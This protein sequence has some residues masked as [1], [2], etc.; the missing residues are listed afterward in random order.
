M[1]K[2]EGADKLNHAVVNIPADKLPRLVKLESGDNLQHIVFLDDIIRDNL[3]CI[4]TGFTIHACYSF[5]ITR[6]SELFLDEEIIQEDMLQEMEKKLIKRDMGNPTR[7]LYEKGM[8]LS[9]QNFLAYS[10][11]LKQEELYEGGRYHNLSNLA[12]LP[13][14]RE[15]P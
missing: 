5:K 11:G 6:N 14:T 1:L 13:V 8:P 7:F 2:K 3:N 4:F 12:S 9:V 15:R 10:L